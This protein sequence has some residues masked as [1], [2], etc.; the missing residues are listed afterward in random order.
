MDEKGELKTS[1]R[2][3]TNYNAAMSDILEHP[4]LIKVFKDNPGLIMDGECYKHG[5]SLQDIN[6][7]ARTQV[8]A[9][10]YTILQF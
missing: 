8:T 7:V 6:S 3:A 9:V 1:S 5:L 4:D 10:D 2:G